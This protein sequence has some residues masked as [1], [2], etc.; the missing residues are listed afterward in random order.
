MKMITDWSQTLGGH[1]TRLVKSPINDQIQCN[2]AHPDYCY[3]KYYS[4]YQS[5]QFTLEI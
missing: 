2:S 4:K 5:N 3:S 1:C